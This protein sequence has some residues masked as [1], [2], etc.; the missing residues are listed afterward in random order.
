MF[1]L[2]IAYGAIGNICFAVFFNGLKDFPT[3]FTVNW[4]S[5]EKIKNIKRFYCLWPKEIMWCHRANFEVLASDKLH[6][7]W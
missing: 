5:S 7:F 4:I 1:V 3:P 2:D 6:V